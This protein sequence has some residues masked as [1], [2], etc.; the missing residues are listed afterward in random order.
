MLQP[1]DYF[2]C[3]SD[4]TRLRC[5]LILH[6]EGELCV[7]EL[8]HALDL[9]QPKISRH[10]AQLRQYGLLTDSRKGQW[11]YYKIHPELVPWVIDFL[12]ETIKAV[13]QCVIYQQDILRLKNMVDRP[14]GG[15]CCK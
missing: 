4:E 12:D 9:S 1:V 7:C 2:K 11:V 5:I 14:V 10:L 6:V 13:E 8:T 15:S 3:L